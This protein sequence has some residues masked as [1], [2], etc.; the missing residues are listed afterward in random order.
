MHNI[1]T[2]ESLTEVFDRITRKVTKQ[3]AGIYLEPGLTKPSGS[4]YT[5]YA[6]FEGGFNTGLSMCAEATMFTRLTRYMIGLDDVTQEA[7]EDV[8]TEYFNMVCGC[9]ASHLFKITKIP[10]RF[11]IPKFYRGRYAPEGHDEH[12]ILTYVSDG[13]ESVQLIHHMPSMVSA[14]A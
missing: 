7:V 13:Q 9:I 11:T 14:D 5:V 3:A 4:L 1:I 10:S 12:L 2:Q 8:S 6:Q